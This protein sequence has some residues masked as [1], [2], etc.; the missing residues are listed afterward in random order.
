MTPRTDAA[1]RR[2]EGMTLIEL[3][4]ASSLLLV[5]MAI[6]FTT[7]LGVKDGAERA[8]TQ[9]DLNEEGRNALNR[10]V[11]E[12]R[13]ASAITWAVN[14]DGPAYDATALTALSL[15]ADFNGDG[16]IA[17]AATATTTCPVPVPTPS[18][19]NPEQLTYCFD[20]QGTAANRAYLWL[21]P[22]A[23]TSVPAD[24]D[25]AGA[26]PILAGN[27]AL[28]SVEYRSNEY[29]FD[30]S[31]PFGVTTWRELDAAPVPTGDGSVGGD[32]DIN[33]AAVRSINSVVLHLDMAKDGKKQSYTTQVDVR[34]KT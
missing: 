27:V 17:G 9:H 26:E 1:S 13:Q 6:S 16:C 2:D 11:R 30:T 21:I 14:P 20:P 33:T 31:A 32:G 10:M 23:L 28:F 18:V 7:L 29:R 24:C 3:L 12:L 22:I 15:Q 5:L 34:N 25:F 8:R 19:T 4:V